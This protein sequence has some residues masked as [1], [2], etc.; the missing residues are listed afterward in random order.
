MSSRGSLNEHGEQIVSLCPAVIPP[1]SYKY[2]FS[3]PKRGRTSVGELIFD[4]IASSSRRVSK[5]NRCLHADI[6]Y[7]ERVYTYGWEIAGMR[8]G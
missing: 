3:S 1:S 6:K 2:Q 4:E 5:R 8:V 7:H